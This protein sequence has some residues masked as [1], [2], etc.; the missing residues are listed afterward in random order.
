[1]SK[2]DRDSDQRQLRAVLF[3]DV[4]GYTRLMSRDEEHTQARIRELLEE[5]ERHCVEYE[6]NVLEVR[7][8]GLFCTF[9]SVVNSIRFAVELQNLSRQRN[10]DQSGDEKL[11]FRVGI[12]IGDVLYDD[13]HYYGDTV[14]LAARIEGSADPGGICISGTVFELVKN[15]L[16]YGYT[17]LG[18]KEF[19]NIEEPVDVYAISSSAPGVV[20]QPTR[21]TR[22]KDKPKAP[23]ELNRPSVVVLPFENLSGN[24]EEDY[25]SD[26]ITEDITTHLSKFKNLFVIARSSAFSFKGKSVVTQQIG[27][28][29]GV[30]YIAE[31]SIRQDPKRL[32]VSVQLV[33]ADSGHNVWTE[34]F[35]RVK[36]D[37]FAVQDEITELV[38]AATA[39]QIEANER[40]RIG[41]I[42]EADL[43]AYSM[44]LQGQQ[45]IFMYRKDLNSEA[46]LHY[47]HALEREPEYAR[48]L[49]AISRTYNFDWR[50]SW[51]N[52]P[53]DALDT[54]LELAQSSVN[55]DPQDPRGHS[56]L[57]F[58]YLYRKEHDLCINAYEKAIRLNPNDADVM[59]DMADALAHSGR[60]DEAIELLSRAMRLNP[61][62]PDLY[63]WNLAGAQY[64]L[65]QYDE[66]IQAV[67][68]MNNPTEGRRLLTASYAQLG[69]MEHARQHA[70]KLLEAHPTFSADHWRHILPD[71][72][73]EET[74]HFVEGL[75]KAGL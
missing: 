72:F 61:Y 35:D 65:K 7:G 28:E 54:A 38:V 27:K 10:R 70:T 17:Y 43:Q 37:I 51:A 3:A 52:S 67:L 21:R 44:V 24:P 36:D 48:A 33:D 53:D 74:E 63:L 64:N 14:N 32:R 8:D 5:F 6:G 34:R 30:R 66:A 18:A 62:Y 22:V 19:K 56:E 57:G 4:V 46:R 71:K 9:R 60:S 49:A 42:R 26:G 29:L 68:K 75:K 45:K 73:P 47:E 20:M 50:Y 41:K 1:M 55:I 39:V 40:A 15:R 23:Q 16:P 12:N 31:G 13:T 69:D 11:E 59:A 58:V 2:N 25:F